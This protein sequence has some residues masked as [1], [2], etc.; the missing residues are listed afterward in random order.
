M[1]APK[2]ARVSS[3]SA[4]YPY[5]ESENVLIFG[6]D[7]FKA[8]VRRETVPEGTLFVSEY[9]GLAI[10]TLYTNVAE[11]GCYCEASAEW[12][13][14]Y[15]RLRGMD[16][17]RAQAQASMGGGILLPGSPIGPPGPPISKEA[18]AIYGAYNAALGVLG[19]FLSPLYPIDVFEM[20]RHEEDE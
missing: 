18:M 11:D 13:G 2:L 12:Q 3:L 15:L 5:F 4:D 20:P 8:T 1:R 16:V 14:A 9:R 10:H 19:G 17:I 6:V 7:A